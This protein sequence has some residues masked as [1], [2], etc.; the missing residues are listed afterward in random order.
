M[1]VTPLHVAPPQ[2]RIL[3]QVSRHKC[4]CSSMRLSRLATTYTQ[5]EGGDSSGL[6]GKGGR[7][8]PPRRFFLPTQRLLW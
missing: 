5:R 1:A 6:Y 3:R 4:V 8:L 7:V 2:S